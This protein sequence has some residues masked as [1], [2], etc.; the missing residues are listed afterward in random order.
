MRRLKSPPLQFTTPLWS[1]TGRPLVRRF[2]QNSPTLGGRETNPRT[3]RGYVHHSSLPHTIVED[4]QKIER[5]H[6]PPQPRKPAATVDEELPPLTPEQKEVLDAILEG[7]NVFIGGPVGSGKSAIIEHLTHHLSR[8]GKS[9]EV[10]NLTN[11]YETARM[12]WQP[13][14]FFFP[15]RKLP[16]HCAPDRAKWQ[17]GW[18]GDLSWATQTW[19]WSQLATGNPFYLGRGTKTLDSGKRA[20]GRWNIYRDSRERIRRPEVVVMTGATSTSV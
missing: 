8:L 7:Q 12:G 17:A 1:R 9:Y 2:I 19:V 16:R 6:P 11:N 13:I 5:E 18:I 14:G 3:A 20:V 10:L 4:Q 15:F